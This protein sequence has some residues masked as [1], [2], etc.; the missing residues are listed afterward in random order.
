MIIIIINI[1]II[2]IITHLITIITFKSFVDMMGTP[3]VTY[4]LYTLMVHSFIPELVLHSIRIVRYVCAY[5]AAIF[6]I[7]KCTFP[8]SNI[9]FFLFSVMCVDRF[10]FSNNDATIY[11]QHGIGSDKN[12]SGYD[13]VC[14]FPCVLGYK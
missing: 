8:P 9:I 12:D 14:V 4:V 2:I 6:I 10:S 5:R 3:A 1:I 11:I 13:S 7:R